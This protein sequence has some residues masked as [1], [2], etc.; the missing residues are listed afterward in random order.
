VANWTPHSITAGFSNTIWPARLRSSNIEIIRGYV[1]LGPGFCLTNTVPKR[2]AGFEGHEIAY[3]PLADH[4]PK[5]AITAVTLAAG[6]VA[7]A[8]SIDDLALLRHGGMKRLFTACYA[9]STLGSFLRAFTF[10]H[11]RQLDAVASRFLTNLGTLARLLGRP[12]TE[13]FLFVDV[14]DT[15]IEI[16]GY[17]KQ[18][19]GYG[20]YSRVRG[21]N[22]LLAAVSPK[23]TAPRHGPGPALRPGDASHPRNACLH[24]T[25]P[26]GHP[27]TRRKLEPNREHALDVLA[28][29][30]FHL[31]SDAD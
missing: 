2:R 6:M 12:G 22:A 27:L 31:L 17:Q 30:W 25:G 10:G 14:N 9:P 29:S 16:H 28:D 23:D 21:L 26:R 19:S 18:G 24:A 13:D 3:V 8:D 5:N 20:G 11:V 15:I 7:G 4:V 1:A